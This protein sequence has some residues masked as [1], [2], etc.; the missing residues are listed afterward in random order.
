MTKAN[1]ST[2]TSPANFAALYNPLS[3]SDKAKIDCMIEISLVLMNSVQRQQE[4]VIQD[5][6]ESGK[7]KESEVKQ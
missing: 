1:L 7:L 5:A 2:S 6:I 4:A 3:H